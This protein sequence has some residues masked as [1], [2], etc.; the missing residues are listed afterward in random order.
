MYGYINYSSTY[1][2][3]LEVFI[4]YLY[5][6]VTKILLFQRKRYLHQ[7]PSAIII[8]LFIH[9]QFLFH[10]YVCQALY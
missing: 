9:L 1:K 8:Y 2:L 10:V 6:L 7:I 3:P 5:I 4:F